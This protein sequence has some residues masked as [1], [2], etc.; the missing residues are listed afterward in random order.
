MVISQ[1]RAIASL[2]LLL[3]LVECGLWYLREKDCEI[4]RASQ[5]NTVN[6][7]QVS[8]VVNTQQPS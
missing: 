2:S 7:C 5:V 1:G 6:C 4:E 8:T 3:S